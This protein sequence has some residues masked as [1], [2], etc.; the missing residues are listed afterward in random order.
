[1]QDSLFSAQPAESNETIEQINEELLRR[2]KSLPQF[3]ERVFIFG[4]GSS[5]A[6]AAV[7]GESPGPPDIE[8]GRPFMGP[9]GQMLERILSSV[10]LARS[11]CYLT[12]V[13]K[14]IST[15]D[16][17]TPEWLSFFTP[18][19]HRE[20]AAARP[21]VIIAFGNTP[22]RALLRTKKPISQMRGEF[23]DYDGR[24]LMPTFN[25]AY[26]LRDPTKKREVWED[27]KK[28]RTLLALKQK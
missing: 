25:P 10:G 8:S 21:R 9:A 2:A 27:M 5:G 19:L 28:I 14:A 11:D 6:K 24:P 12:N 3:K 15:G 20:L 13:I 17:I 7:V 18:Y 26:L 22:T 16:E 4:E 23:H 1:M